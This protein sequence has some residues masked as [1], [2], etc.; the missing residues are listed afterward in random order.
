MSDLVHSLSLT[1][2]PVNL[3]ILISSYMNLRE[4][5]KFG[6]VNRRCK[7]ISD[8]YNLWAHIFP[9]IPMEDK[10]NTFLRR[11]KIALNIRKKAVLPYLL[12]AHSDM[13]LSVDVRDQEIVSS[14]RDGSIAKWNLDTKRG[15]VYHGH[16]DWV[17]AA[18][19]YEHG[20]V[21]VSAD[22]S[23][24]IWTE[25]EPEGK[26]LRGHS[27]GVTCLK[28]ANSVTGVTGAHDNTV[29][30]WDLN[31]GKLM[32]NYTG[33][34]SA[35]NCLDVCEPWVVSGTVLDGKVLLRDMLTGSI[36]QTLQL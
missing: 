27:A 1:D 19:F 13:V 15:T 35:I 20:V 28:L 26:I 36:V 33:H 12:Q 22:R 5:C 9:E 23:V 4:I 16:S 11:S 29:K 2:L 34:D 24:R 17:V 18:K 31:K 32:S 3:L 30:I 7:E 14:S 6:A 10:K 21:S 8:N 25:E